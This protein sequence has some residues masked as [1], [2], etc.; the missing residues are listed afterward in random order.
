MAVTF[1]VEDGT[2]MATSN[3]YVSVSYADDYL[4]IRPHTAPWLN[5]SSTDKEKYLMLATRTLDRRAIFRGEKVVPES[6]LRWPRAGAS[7][8][9]GVGQAYD[10]VPDAIKHATVELAY[11]F[12]FHDIDPSI[13]VSTGGAIKRIKADVLEIE[14][15]DG[16]QNSAGNYLPLGINDILRC[17]GRISTGNGSSFGRILRA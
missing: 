10:T 14:Y 8:C 16:T 17:L 7:D 3:S 4:V 12:V 13:S 1:T 5:L 9:D 15:Q 6:A 11:N 2:G